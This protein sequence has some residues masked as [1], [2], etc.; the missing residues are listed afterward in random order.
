MASSMRIMP[1]KYYIPDNVNIVPPQ[2]ITFAWFPNTPSWGEIFSYF[3]SSPSSYNI[4]FIRP[5]SYQMKY[6]AYEMLSLASA[7]EGD[8]VI[9][10]NA[11]F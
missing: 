2:M 6:D 10:S 4:P 8:G 7:T 1:K 5:S 3:I 11:A 9:G